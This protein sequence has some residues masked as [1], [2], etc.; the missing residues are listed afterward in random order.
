MSGEEVSK[1]PSIRHELDHEVDLVRRA[2]AR[3]ANAWTEIY[4]QNQAKLFRYVQARVGDRETAEDLTATVFLE[5]L[6]GIGSYSSR[7]RPL[8][9][10][11]Y[12]I[13]RNVVN[14]HH[15]SSFRRRS[16]PSTAEVTEGGIQNILGA[17]R[18]QGSDDPGTFSSEASDPASA[19]E[20]WDLR[21][22]ICRLSD[23][24]REVI[25]L[26]YFVGLTT[27]EVAGIVGKHERA[28]YSLQT[29]AIKALRRHLR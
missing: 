1:D 2:R 12:A 26:R 6:K 25:V 18:S 20:G 27:P 29:R 19:A 21:D 24:Q 17:G 7:G 28:V 10:W 13:A 16:S 8:L 23:D 14:Y 22:A 11:L 3:S 15:R 5:A 4:E 9:A